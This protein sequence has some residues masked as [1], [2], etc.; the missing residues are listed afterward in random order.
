MDNMVRYVLMVGCLCPENEGSKKNITKRPNLNAIRRTLRAGKR[1]HL[2][3]QLEHPW[4]RGIICVT[5]RKGQRSIKS[6]ALAIVNKADR[7]KRGLRS[8]CDL[9]KNKTSVFVLREQVAGILLFPFKKNMQTM[10]NYLLFNCYCIS[11]TVNNHAANSELEQQIN[12]LNKRID[13]PFNHPVGGITI[14][15]WREEACCNFVFSRFLFFSFRREPP[16]ER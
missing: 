4:G 3:F 13:C 16:T 6:I 11:R 9:N 14:I 5:I 1:S 7:I 8:R 12:T 10:Q 15:V 2:Y